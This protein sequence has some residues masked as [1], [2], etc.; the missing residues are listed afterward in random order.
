MSSN[1]VPV[2]TPA[3]F[4]AYFDRMATGSGGAAA[5]PPIR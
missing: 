4:L 1:A 2:M 5:V 3:E